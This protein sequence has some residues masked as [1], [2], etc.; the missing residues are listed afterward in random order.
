MMRFYATAFSASIAALQRAG[1]TLVLADGWP[2]D[3][4]RQTLQADLAEGTSHFDELP[5]SVVVQDQIHRLLKRVHDEEEPFDRSTFHALVTEVY[6]NVL[7]DLSQS[8]FLMIPASRRELY[9]QF[10]PPFGEG[11]A[12]QF[13]G[14]A[15]D[16]AAAARCIALDEWTAAVFHLM[17][18]L[19]G[20][21]QELAGWLSVV[22]SKGAGEQWKNALD[23]IEKALREMEQLPASP[24]KSAALTF[25][26]GAVA[27]FRWFKDAWRNHVSHARTHYDEREALAVFNNVRPFMQQ[28]AEHKAA[29]L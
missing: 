16:I 4:L 2:D 13:P 12:E 26:S 25:Y 1:A 10:Y 8:W 19:E 18:V 9:Q 17:R 6:N 27:Q 28:L 15:K 29:M 20:G 7:R 22:L 21:I 11:V 14:Q 23:Q 5:L 24:Q 3:A